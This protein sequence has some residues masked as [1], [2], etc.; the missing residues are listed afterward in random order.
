MSELAW[1]ALQWRHNEREGAS[2]HHSRDGL[3]NCLFRCRSK[4]T[5]KLRV[6]GLCAENSPVTGEFSAQKPSNAENGSIWWRHHAGTDA[7]T[8]FPAQRASNAVNVSIWWRHNEQ[9]DV[10]VIPNI[11]LVNRWWYMS[12][13]TLCGDFYSYNNMLYIAKT[14]RSSGGFFCIYS[15]TRVFETRELP[16]YYFFR[17]WYRAMYRLLFVIWKCESYTP[18]RF[19]NWS[20]SID[21][22]RPW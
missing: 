21:E 7:I 14:S 1:T 16:S 20:Y 6:T 5:S 22:N 13:C 18:I 9:S 8:W 15:R 11:W 17:Q 10:H 19:Y 2:N 3:L 4:K 12:Q